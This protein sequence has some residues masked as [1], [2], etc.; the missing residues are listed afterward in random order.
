MSALSTYAESLALERHVKLR[1]VKLPF[2]SGFGALF[3]E[4]AEMLRPEKREFLT[5]IARK[6][7]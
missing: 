2:I 5:L 1:G 3:A 7:S 6:P 4:L